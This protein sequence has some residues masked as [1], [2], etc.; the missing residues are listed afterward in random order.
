MDKKQFIDLIDNMG[1]E[2]VNNFR[3]GIELEDGTEIVIKNN[4]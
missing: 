1:I 4:E 2:K 3:L